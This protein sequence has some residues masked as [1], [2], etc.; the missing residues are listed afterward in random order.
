MTLNYNIHYEERCGRM[1]VA[2]RD[3]AAGEIIFQVILMMMVITCHET[4]HVTHYT[5]QD[6]PA[7]MGADNNPGPICLTCYK[8]LPGVT[9]TRDIIRDTD[10][11]TR[12]GV[13]VPPLRLASLRAPLSAG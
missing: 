6:K 9:H 5:L 1:L 10:I 2:A 13:Q 3:I 12:S 4:L 7:A 11:V 8:R